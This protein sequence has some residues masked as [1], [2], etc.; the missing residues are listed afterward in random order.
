M[1][2]P[3]KKKQNSQVGVLNLGLFL[4]LLLLLG[5]FLLAILVVFFFGRIGTFGIRARNR[6]DHRT[7][8]TADHRAD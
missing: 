6:F 8:C 3:C 7:N 1:D 4:G 2:K 5:R